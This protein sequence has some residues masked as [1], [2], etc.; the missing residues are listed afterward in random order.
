ML[1]F[2]AEK[3]AELKAMEHQ[4]FGKFW[5]TVRAGPRLDLEFDCGDL[6]ERLD[7]LRT[8]R[9]DKGVYGGSGWANYAAAYFNDCLAFCRAAWGLMKPGGTAVVVIG[10]NILQGVEL[11][12]DRYFA[13]IAEGCGFEVVDL[14]RV[15]KKR[16]GSSILNSSVRRGTAKQR[17]ELYESAIELRPRPR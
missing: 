11:K 1:D 14:H 13:A 7:H 8:L 10:N 15:R 12:T 17:V 4:S 5:Q 16:T 9:A 3:R 6:A 2:I